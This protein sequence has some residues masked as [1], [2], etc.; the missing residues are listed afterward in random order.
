MQHQNSFAT[1]SF[2]QVRSYLWKK[3]VVSLL[4]GFS[5]RRSQQVGPDVSV[6][7]SRFSKVSAL[8]LLLNNDLAAA[9]IPRG[10][11][12]LLLRQGERV[13]RGD[14]ETGSVFRHCLLLL[15]L[16]SGSGSAPNESRSWD[17]KFAPLERKVLHYTN[18]VNPV[19]WLALLR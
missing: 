16:R 1:V 8:F 13:T 17:A 12:C 19:L 2:D 4:Y 18:R 10:Q 5:A 15:Q 7:S 14:V 6:A 9:S 11:G 3:T